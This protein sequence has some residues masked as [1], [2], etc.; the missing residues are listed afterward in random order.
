MKRAS[1]LALPVLRLSVTGAPA[2]TIVVDWTGAGDETYL[3]DG[4]SSAASGDTVL[5]TP[6]IYLGELNRNLYFGGKDLLKGQWG[7]TR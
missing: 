3:L 6:G 7:R 5:V 1:S 4:T 2:D